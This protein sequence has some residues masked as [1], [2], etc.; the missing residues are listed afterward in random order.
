MQTRAVV[1]KNLATRVPAYQYPAGTR[2]PILLGVQECK[3]P[4]NLGLEVLGFGFVV[5][6]ET[7]GFA[8]HLRPFQL[9][10]LFPVRGRVAFQILEKK[11]K[12]KK[13]FSASREG[14]NL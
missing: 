6:F 4:A 14:K 3:N 10:F 1:G 7:L 2:V 12:T 11:K 5:G 8:H 9:E 13:L